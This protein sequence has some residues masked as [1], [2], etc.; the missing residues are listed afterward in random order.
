M[1]TLVI[2][3]RMIRTS[4]EFFHLGQFAQFPYESIPKGFSLV[5][6][7]LFWPLIVY[8]KMLPQG[9]NNHCSCLFWCYICLGI[10]SKVICDN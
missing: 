5:S 9:P 6:E 1:L 7:N 3:F 8:Q 4:T 10:F 2:G